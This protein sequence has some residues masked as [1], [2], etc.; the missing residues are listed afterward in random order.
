MDSGSSTLQMPPRLAGSISVMTYSE[1]FMFKNKCK[2]TGKQTNKHLPK[3][4]KNNSTNQTNSLKHSI[5]QANSQS[6]KQ[7]M[8][9]SY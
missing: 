8:I 2:A 6:V 5:K 9:Q 3:Q 4:K 7:R 1:C